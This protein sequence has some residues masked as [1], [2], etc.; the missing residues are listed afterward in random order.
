MCR[1]IMSFPLRVRTHPTPRLLVNINASKV[2]KHRK[3]QCYKQI[4][5]WVGPN[6]KKI[7]YQIT[8]QMKLHRG[9]GRLAQSLESNRLQQSMK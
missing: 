3:Q 1:Y 8:Y 9:G 2:N 4:V 6:R 5:T 7:T